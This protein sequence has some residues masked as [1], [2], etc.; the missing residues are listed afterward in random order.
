MI[1]YTAIAVVEIPISFEA[2]D[3]HDS[4]VDAG[5]DVAE[6]MAKSL[7]GSLVH[8]ENIQCNSFYITTT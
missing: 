8:I 4:M 3:G 1:R 5:H 2:D 7:G 6:R